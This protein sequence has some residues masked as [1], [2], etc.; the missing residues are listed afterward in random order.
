MRACRYGGEEFAV[1]LP[2]TDRKQALQAAERIRYALEHEIWP[3]QDG[4]VVTGSFGL[5]Q[6][7]VDLDSTGMVTCADQA[8]YRA[9]KLGRNRVEFPNRLESEHLVA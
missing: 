9:K 1:I 3:G 2:D 4:L 6:Y 8:L 7:H 5:S